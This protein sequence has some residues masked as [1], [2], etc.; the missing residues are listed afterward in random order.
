MAHQDPLGLSAT[1]GHEAI[2]VLQVSLVPQ[3]RKARLDRPVLLEVVVVAV[4]Q[5]LL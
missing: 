3:V 5:P 2:S 4:D 1:S